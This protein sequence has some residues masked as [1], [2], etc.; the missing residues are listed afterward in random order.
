MTLLLCGQDPRA[1]VTR[2]RCACVRVSDRVWSCKWRD[3][4]ARVPA[5]ARE[6]EP[7][8]TSFLGPHDK[9]LLHLRLPC[10]VPSADKAGATVGIKCKPCL[11]YD[12]PVPLVSSSTLHCLHHVEGRTRRKT[13][14]KRRGGWGHAMEYAQ[15]PT[16]C[17]T[18]AWLRGPVAAVCLRSAWD[19]PKGMQRS[20]AMEHG[21]R[22]LTVRARP[23][24][25]GAIF[26]A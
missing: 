4:R 16:Y 11:T 9:T 2:P 6:R 14:R 3:D 13:R 1:P 5:A 23:F 17:S 18:A 25:A 10:F 7:G 19:P 12:S 24:D 21:A 8:P 15:S 22:E 20:E 26:S